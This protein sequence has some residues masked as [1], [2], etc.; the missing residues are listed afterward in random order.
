MSTWRVRWENC[1]RSPTTVP[2]AMRVL[3]HPPQACD[4]VEGTYAVD[5]PYLAPDVLPGS[6]GCKA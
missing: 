5:K 3:H 1:V 2:G 6:P 4:G